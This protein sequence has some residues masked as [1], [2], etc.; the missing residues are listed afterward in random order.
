MYNLNEIELTELSELLSDA[1]ERLEYSEYTAW[2]SS[3]TC[4]SF[5]NWRSKST[6]DTINKLNSFGEKLDV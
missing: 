5:D 3:S 1:A 6:L 2:Y 4:T